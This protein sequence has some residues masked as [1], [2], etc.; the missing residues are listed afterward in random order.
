MTKLARKRI[1]AGLSV[2]ELAEQSQVS[3]SAIYAIETEAVR[4]PQMRTLRALAVPLGCSVLDLIPDEPT[5]EA[6]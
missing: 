2:Q 4:R 1:E 3:P 6:A 5:E